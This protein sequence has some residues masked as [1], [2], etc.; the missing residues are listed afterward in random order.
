MTKK[1]LCIFFFLMVINGTA[2]SQN[3]LLAEQQNEYYVRTLRTFAS[4]M[5]N[6]EWLPPEQR[7]SI[8]E[9]MLLNLL[10]SD[11]SFVE[12]Y[13]VWKPNA[14]DG[15][16][17]MFIYDTGSAQ[18]GQYALVFSRENGEIIKK[19]RTISEVYSSMS[20]FTGPNAGINK[21][22]NPI[23]RNINGQNTFVIDLMVPIINPQTNEVVGGVGCIFI[24][25]SQ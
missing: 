3:P 17:A 13:T 22:D 19:T 8:F 14:L 5:S 23:R 25:K 1:W 20:W 4:I 6:Y 10:I 12:I 15:N 2:F 24:D 21:V 18:T 7:R 9:F 16:D 11:E